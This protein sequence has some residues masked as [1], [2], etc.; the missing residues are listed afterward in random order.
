MIFR[1]PVFQCDMSVRLNV[2]WKEDYSGYGLRR[3]ENDR[4]GHKEI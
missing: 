1:R 3:L 2:G 4:H